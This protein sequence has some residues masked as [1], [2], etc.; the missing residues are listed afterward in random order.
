MRINKVALAVTALL[1]AS[2]VHA[3]GFQVS[4]HSASGLGR[5]FAG[6][7][8]IGDDAASLA[9]NP[10]LM[11]TFDKA[12]LSVVGSYVS[13]E[14]D[15]TSDTAG[16][17]NDV[18]PAQAVPAMYYIQPINDQW[19][20]GLAVYSNYGTGTEYPD[21]YNGT[22][23]GTTHI[24]S[25]NFNPNIS[26]RVNDELSF[27][28]G[29]SLVYAT[30]ELKRHAGS[31]DN[32]VANMEGDGYGFGW[33]VG[34]L[35]EINKNNRLGISY[36]SK[37]KTEL[38]GDYTGSSTAT[39]LNPFGEQNTVDGTL[40]INLPSILEVSGY[41]KLSDKFAV[42]YSWQYTTWSDF[43]DIEAEGADCNDVIG[44]GGQGVCLIKEEDFSNSS[45][46]AVG[47]EYYLSEAITLRAGYALDEQAGE[48]TLA[49][50]DTDRHWYTAGVT[51]KASQALS[52]DFAA[53]LVAGKEITFV[54]SNQTFTSSGDAY[55]Y[56]A[57]MN[58]SF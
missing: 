25:V 18:A 20:A 26:Y 48:S 54:E 36:K 32:N 28:A 42:S 49:I 5:A 45:R 19:A 57:Q 50:P 3:A 43:G 52:F 33:N 2:Q 31:I 6:E 24:V 39:G 21:G 4:E 51:Y 41:H 56:S 27:G 13:P 23:A 16:N 58:Y 35:Y 12:Q 37:V 1:A 40:D 44:G 14:I 15:V 30:A 38:E 10:A 53:A 55:I 8:A 46:Y 22:I 9:R 34:A 11:A 17:A 29:V 7:A 47:G